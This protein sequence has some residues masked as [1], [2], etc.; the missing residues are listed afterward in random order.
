MIIVGAR[1]AKGVNRRILDDTGSDVDNLGCREN[2]T[3]LHAKSMGW[4]LDVADML[5]RHEAGVWNLDAGAYIP[6]MKAVS[7]NG[8]YIFSTTGGNEFFAVLHVAR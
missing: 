3:L 1:I 2:T 5:F 8:L 4:S 7:S 6:R